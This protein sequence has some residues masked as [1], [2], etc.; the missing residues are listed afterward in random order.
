MLTETEKL[1]AGLL[2]TSVETLAELLGGPTLLHLPGRRTEPL[3]VT[4]LAHGNESTG[5]YAVQALLR[6]YH[7]RELPRA[8]SIFVG[9]VAA[10]RH[11]P[12]Y[13][14]PSLKGTV[15]YPSAIGGNNWGAPAVDLDRK[16]MV[17]I[18]ASNPPTGG[19]RKFL[20]GER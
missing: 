13:T 6:K 19:S 10:A 4:I 11:G 1:P 8:L 7:N 5:F 20:P 12:I 3:F 14:P 18:A 17:G 9:N 2:E 16:I 15:Y